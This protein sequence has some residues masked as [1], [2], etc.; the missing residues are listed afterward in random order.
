M[1]EKFSTLIR[2]TFIFALGNFGSKIILFFMVPLYTNFLS[3][4]E[5]G[6]ADYVFTM[7]QLLVPIFSISIWEGVVR[8]GLK[9]GVKKEDVFCN[10][11]LVY[12]FSFF[13]VAATTPLWRFYGPIA[14]WRFFLSIYSLSY[15][16]N[17][18]FLNYIKIKNKNKLFAISSIIQTL[19][20]ALLNILLLVKMHLGVKGYLISNIVAVTVANILVFF[21]A[22][23]YKDVIIGHI[24]IPLLKRMVMYA[25]PLIVSN[26]SWWIIHSSDKIMIESM[27]TTGELGLYTAASKIPALINV[28][29]AV[30]TQAW[31]LSSIREME[32]TNDENYYTKVFEVYSVILFIFLLVFTTL[33]RPFMSIYVGEDF[34]ESWR[35]VPLLFYAAVYQAFSS[36]FGGLLG[37]L[38]KS[39]STMISALIG[40]IVNIIL[41]YFFIRIVGVW[42][43]LIGTVS[44]FVLITLFRRAI[45]RKYLHLR[46][47]WGIFFFNSLLCL[48]VVILSSISNRGLLIGALGLIVFLAFNFKQIKELLVFCKR[49]LQRVTNR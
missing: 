17:Q 34:I 21:V 23:L 20:L 41:N 14:Q 6:I 33:L 19:V 25:S 10:S 2:D 39:T 16:L 13:L 24:N 48:T 1:N 12:A 30:F 9:K 18:I 15:I 29:V 11:L 47:N 8:I 5:Y 38:Q 26:I 45:I 28:L 4:E 32:S 37:A 43:A 27:L 7:S 40:S 22:G 31:S 35:F 42:G 49:L 3:R 46:I 36:Y 44:A